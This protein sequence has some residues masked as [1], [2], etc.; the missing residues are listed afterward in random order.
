MN[1]ERMKKCLRYITAFVF[2]VLVFLL[3]FMPFFIIPAQA[4]ELPDIEEYEE[5]EEQQESESP[6]TPPLPTPPQPPLQQAYNYTAMLDTITM[7]LLRIAQHIES[8][9]E[10]AE[11]ERDM[12]LEYEYVMLYVIAEEMLE[13]IRAQNELIAVAL[14]FVAGAIIGVA[15]LSRFNLGA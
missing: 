13:E 6:A 5:Y 4:A 8:E 9:P 7:L 2:A 12:Y 3:M 15:V 1:D 14:G 10:A 11:P